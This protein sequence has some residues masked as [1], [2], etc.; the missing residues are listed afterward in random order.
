MEQ[1]TEHYEG[2]AWDPLEAVNEILNGIH[3][4]DRDELEFYDMDGNVTGEGTGISPMQFSVT[5]YTREDNAYWNLAGTVINRGR[6]DDMRP[7]WDAGAELQ[8]LEIP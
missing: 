7:I 2:S 3:Y 8:I 4:T 6:A 1:E 5:L